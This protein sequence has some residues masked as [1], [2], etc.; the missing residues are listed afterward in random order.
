MAG[1]E[2]VGPMSQRPSLGDVG[3]ESI[4]SQAAV[5]T[6]QT[7]LCAFRW[8]WTALMVL[9]TSLPYLVNF[10]STPA[11]YRYTWILP[12]YPEDS[13]SYM[14]WSAAGCARSAPV[15]DKVH[16]LAAVSIFVSSLVPDMRMD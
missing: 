12:P 10:A 13:L 9:A 4:R 7:G 15:Q 2:N 14:A 8:G 1:Q 6:N 11:G 16:S 5:T 3:E